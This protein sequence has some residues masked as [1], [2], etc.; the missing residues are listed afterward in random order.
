MSVTMAA[1][2]QEPSWA[3]KRLEDVRCRRCHA[4]LCMATADPLKAQALVQIKCWK[5]KEMNYL[6][7]GLT[8]ASGSSANTDPHARRAAAHTDHAV[9][10]RGH[11]GRHPGTAGG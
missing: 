3:E 10:E 1:A 6:F 8:D 9:V 2:G 4:K 11:E 7:G 5:C